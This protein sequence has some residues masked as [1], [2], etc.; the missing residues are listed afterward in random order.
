[1]DSTTQK[2]D[3]TKSLSYISGS[4][5]VTNNGISI[6]PSFSLDKPAVQF[7]LSMGKNRLSFEPDIRFSLKGKP[8]SMLFWGRY[9]L[10][11]N[12]K[13]KMN[14]GTHLGLNF[15]T[16]VL[17]INGDTSEVTITRRYLAFELSPNYF[18]SKNISVGMYYLY[19]HGLDA[20]TIGN[21]HF[22]TL[23]ANFSNIKLTDQF[24][25]KLNPQ[26][27]Y[28]KLDAQDGFYFT[29]SFTVAKKN[30]PLSASEFASQLNVHVNHLNRAIKETSDKTTSQIIGERIVQEAKILLKHSP[31][32]V[33]EIGYALGFTETTHFN[34]FFKKHVQLSPLKFRNI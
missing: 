16:S 30:F 10:V 31:W 25:M 26:F 19:S 34:N 14:V 27:Y 22:I 3:S 33:S 24:F 12:P 6:V 2:K 21:T 11:T 23:N 18:L 9:K 5:G 1:M 28:L 20:G 7:N 15:K 8:W 13:F 4:I 32:N 29:S 17:P